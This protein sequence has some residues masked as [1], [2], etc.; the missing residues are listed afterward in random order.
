MNRALLASA[1]VAKDPQIAIDALRGIFATKTQAEWVKAFEGRDCCVCP[2]QT[3]DELLDDPHLERLFLGGAHEVRSPA[4]RLTQSFA[5]WAAEAD[6]VAGIDLRAAVLTRIAALALDHGHGGMIL[7]VPAE[8][9]APLGVRVHYPVSEGQDLLAKRY[10][11]VT[12]GVPVERRLERGPR[13]RRARAFAA[14]FRPRPRRAR[15]MDHR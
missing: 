8:V 5:Q 6:P 13:S 14:R 15:A 1:A 7:L 12:R 11:A 9:R 3:F 10:A 4:R 2:I